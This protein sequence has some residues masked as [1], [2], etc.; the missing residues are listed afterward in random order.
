MGPP[1][2][3]REFSLALSGKRKAP[4]YLEPSGLSAACAA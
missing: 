3:S 4:G 2:C 1:R